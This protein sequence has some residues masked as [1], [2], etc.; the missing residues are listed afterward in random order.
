MLT[1]EQTI[2]Q[3]LAWG[4]GKK[5]FSP[6]IIFFRMGNLCETDNNSFSIYN[7]MYG[8]QSQTED[9]CKYMTAAFLFG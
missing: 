3:N 2:R 5:G 8:T 4:Q 7:C 9:A 1:V 6:Q